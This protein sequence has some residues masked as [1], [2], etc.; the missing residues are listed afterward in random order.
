[1]KLRPL[2][3][4]E[5][6]TGEDQDDG[7]PWL[8]A[9]SSSSENESCSLESSRSSSPESFRSSYQWLISCLNSPNQNCSDKNF[10]DQNPFDHQSPD[11]QDDNWGNDHENDDLF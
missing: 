6:T 11:W 8:S 10:Y 9:S 3:T 7:L 2:T 4:T 1:V 5:I